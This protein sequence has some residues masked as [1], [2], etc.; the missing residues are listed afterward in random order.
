MMYSVEV[1]LDC[2]ILILIPHHNGIIKLFFLI[3]LIDFDG[4]MIA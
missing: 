1:F 3:L 4:M 2:L